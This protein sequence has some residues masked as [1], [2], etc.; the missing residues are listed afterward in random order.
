MALTSVLFLSVKLFLRKFLLKWFY[1]YLFSF[2]QVLC[3]I[4]IWFNI[5]LQWHSLDVAHFLECQDLCCLRDHK[6]RGIHFE[7]VVVRRV[8]QFEL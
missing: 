6:K 1:I 5:A 3:Q 4:T 8:K 7:V 2:T